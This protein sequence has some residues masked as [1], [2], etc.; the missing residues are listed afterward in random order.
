MVRKSLQISNAKLQ[1]PNAKVTS[2]STHDSE[3][4]KST[5]GINRDQIPSKANF[6][7]KI[8]CIRYTEFVTNAVADSSTGSEVIQRKRSGKY[9][10][11][12]L[13]MNLEHLSRQQ[14]LQVICR[15]PPS[16]ST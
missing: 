15:S 1:I 9:L 7:G 5:K 6:S 3:S 16:N 14:D 8:P 12:A 4:Q 11:S 2:I 13:R 10:D